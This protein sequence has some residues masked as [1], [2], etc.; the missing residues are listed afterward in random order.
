[1]ALT[2]GFVGTGM[3]ATGMDLSSATWTDVDG[4]AT[5][6]ALVPVG[7][8]EQHGPHAP[9]GTDTI[10]AET[11]AVAG[12]DAYTDEVVVTPP[13][14][15]GIAREHRQFPGTLW[16]S[17]DTLRS[18]VRDVVESLAYHGFDRVVLV[19]GHGGNAAAL[20][21]VAGE[22][23]RDEDAYVVSFTWFDIIDEPQMGHGGPV[24]T[25]VVRYIDPDLVREDRTDAAAESGSAG[26]GEW[27]Q[28]VNL[29]HDSAEFTD[30]GVVGDPGETDAE[31]GERL[32][33]DAA[34]A[35]AD[36]LETVAVR[37]VS[38]PADKPG[39]E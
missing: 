33:G 36:L 12:A 20:Q 24:E 37:D 18:Y 11:V 32:L 26:W 31:I 25:A 2:G 3:L 6:L 29:A 8:T 5:D 30:S 19:N 15:V 35:L 16:V 7:S 34:A 39:L 27:T 28:T 10:T 23:T 9:L 4:A 17:P 22:I 14:P 21:E 1:M 38:R 13:I